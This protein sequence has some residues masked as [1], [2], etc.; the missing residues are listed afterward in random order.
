MQREQ[1]AGA[2]PARAAAAAPAAPPTPPVD[3]TERYHRPGLRP[4]SPAELEQ[5]AA[6]GID[7]PLQWNQGGH[8]CVYT[9]CD[10]D[11]TKT[12][13]DNLSA[14]FEKIVEFDG[15]LPEH[16]ASKKGVQKTIQK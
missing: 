9:T 10:E 4:L 2:G 13:V 15:K 7:V 8:R 12:V 14:K 1:Q 3:A 11:L 6:D 16:Y 5:A